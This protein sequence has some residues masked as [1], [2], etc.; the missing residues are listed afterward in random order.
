MIS[1]NTL[2]GIF[3]ILV[4]REFFFLKNLNL[5]LFICC[6]CTEIDNSPKVLS[7]LTFIITHLFICSFVKWCVSWRSCWPVCWLWQCCATLYVI[8][9]NQW[10]RNK[11]KIYWGDYFVIPIRSTIVVCVHSMQYL[12]D[13]HHRIF[14]L[15]F[16]SA[17]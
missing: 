14:P 5:E 16:R 15:S 12:S 11:Q 2:V 7:G 17:F 9:C 13:E 1:L 4:R 3:F 10:S 6:H 8:Q